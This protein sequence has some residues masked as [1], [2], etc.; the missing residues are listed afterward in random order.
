M[1]HKPSKNLEESQRIG[2]ILVHDNVSHA[3]AQY[4]TLTVS[5][6][7]NCIDILIHM[8]NQFQEI[9]SF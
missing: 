2:K 5:Y 6:S 9:P 4:P 3:R 8:S 7:H 1:R